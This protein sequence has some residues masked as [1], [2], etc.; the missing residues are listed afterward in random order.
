LNKGLDTRQQRGSNRQP[1][2]HLVLFLGLYSCTSANE[3][4]RAAAQLA[5]LYDT[6]TEATNYVAVMAIIPPAAPAAACTTEDILV[7]LW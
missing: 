6:R 7:E 5:S 2:T 4:E 3:D 1:A